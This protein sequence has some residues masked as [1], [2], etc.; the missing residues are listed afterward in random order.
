MTPHDL[1][2]LAVVVALL[3][4]FVGGTYFGAGLA[5]HEYEGLITTLQ[6]RVDD[7]REIARGNR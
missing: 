4:G 7:W 1:E 6:R 3:G 5:L 2:L